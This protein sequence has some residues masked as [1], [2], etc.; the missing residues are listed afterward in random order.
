MV[1]KSTI[2][3]QQKYTSKRLTTAQS[4]QNSHSQAFSLLS[5]LTCH[6]NRSA[7]NYYASLRSVCYYYWC[8]YSYKICMVLWPTILHWK[9]KIKYNK[10][11][12]VTMCV[13]AFSCIKTQ[14]KHKQT[15][16]FYDKIHMTLYKH[17]LV[18]IWSC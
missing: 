3:T 10:I 7:W 13:S 4:Q 8:I 18:F 12:K 1:L 14:N 6:M 17:V 16:T 15:Y 9:M 2:H 5:E 11:H